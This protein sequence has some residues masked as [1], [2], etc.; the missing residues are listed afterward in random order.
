MGAN[1]ASHSSRSSARAMAGPIQFFWPDPCPGLG[2]ASWV[3]GYASPTAHAQVA[4]AVLRK[5]AGTFAEV[6]NMLGAC[7]PCP[8]SRRGVGGSMS[9]LE[10]GVLRG[11]GS[12]AARN[13]IRRPRR[14]D[15]ADFSHHPALRGIVAYTGLP[16]TI[17][18]DWHV[19]MASARAAEAESRPPSRGVWLSLVGSPPTV[20]RVTP[21]PRASPELAHCAVHQVAYPCPRTSLSWLSSSSAALLCVEG[22]RR[23]EEEGERVE[24]ERRRKKKLRRMRKEKGMRRRRRS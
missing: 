15:A 7:A 12:C 6:S 1:R 17:V 19:D 5:S 22:G 23:K 10:F 24:E 14:L 20:V 13:R 3:I 21:G 4:V 18:G 2:E 11:V 8:P 9:L 16:P